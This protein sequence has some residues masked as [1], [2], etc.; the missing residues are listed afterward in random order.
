MQYRIL[1]VEVLINILVV[2]HPLNERLHLV[3]KSVSSHP[4]ELVGRSV[5]RPYYI[6]SD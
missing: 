4:N 6:Q 1:M 5:D 3:K 2:L